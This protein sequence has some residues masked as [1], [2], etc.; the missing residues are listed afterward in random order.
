MHRKFLFFLSHLFP[1][2]HQLSGTRLR[3][4]GRQWATR[5]R[6]LARLR[7]HKL[8]KKTKT[9]LF[10]NK[11][12]GD[13]V[14]VMRSRRG[15][16]LSPGDPESTQ[17]SHITVTASQPKCADGRGQKRSRIITD[18]S[19]RLVVRWVRRSVLRGGTKP[20]KVLDLRPSEV[21]APP[22][23]SFVSRPPAQL[24]LKV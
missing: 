22:D 17:A 9:C 21:P 13:S 19:L 5:G 15:S 1:C 18:G 23:D 12:T 7:G 4:K 14:N 3:V 16:D 2:L 8:L 6:R 10:P 11:K 24:R 20:L